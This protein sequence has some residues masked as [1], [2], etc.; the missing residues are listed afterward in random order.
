MEKLT[1]QE[2]IDILQE[3][4]KNWLTTVSKDDIIAVHSYPDDKEY[5]K[6]K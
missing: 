4:P 6:I 1:V 3:L 5:V 2:L